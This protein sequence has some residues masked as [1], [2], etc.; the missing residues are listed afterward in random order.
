MG[1]TLRKSLMWD[2]NF[3]LDSGKEEEQTAD[4]SLLP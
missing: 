2:I 4:F 3:T 1:T